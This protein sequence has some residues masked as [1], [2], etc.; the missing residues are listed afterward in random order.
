M[1]EVRGDWTE[2]PET[3]GKCLFSS[4]MT[5]STLALGAFPTCGKTGA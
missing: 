2:V 4:R 1:Q 5:S 3:P